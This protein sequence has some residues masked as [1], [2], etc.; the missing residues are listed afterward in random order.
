MGHSCIRQGQLLGLDGHIP[1]KE[2]H[3]HNVYVHLGR[4]S[5][6]DDV[7][8]IFSTFGMLKASVYAQQVVWQFE[9]AEAWEYRG[10]ERDGL[11]MPMLP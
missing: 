7:Q 2:A 3:G 8:V 4:I 10:R 11:S 1:H 6:V 5:T 9:F